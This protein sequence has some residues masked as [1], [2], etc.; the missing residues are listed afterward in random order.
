MLLTAVLGWAQ[1]SYN[2][3]IFSEDGEPFYVYANGIRQND[4]PETNVKITNLTS[5]AL[6]MRVQFDNKALPTL[7]QNFMPEFGYEHT[8]NI[9]KNLK[10]T[11]KLQYFGRVPLAEAPRTNAATV[12]YHTAENPVEPQQPAVT[13]G[14]NDGTINNNFP[15]DDQTN[16]VQEGQ[17]VSNTTVTTGQPGSVNINM[18]PGGIS[19]NVNTDGG[20]INNSITTTTTISGGTVTTETVT[21]KSHTSTK[22]G[23]TSPR[24]NSVTSHPVTEV[25]NNN[26]TTGSSVIPRPMNPNA[27]VTASVPVAN[28]GCGVPM[29]SEDYEKLK[30]TVDDTPFADNKISVAKAATKSNCLSVEQVKG[31]CELMP[32]DDHKLIYAKYAYDYCTDKK[33]YYQVG[34]SFSF[35]STQQKLNKFLQTK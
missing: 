5:E 35:P 34:D 23:T 24:H 32:M 18:T 21:T 11:M 33:N 10:K 6:S 25:T 9:K 28:A 19:M 2:I 26:A 15:T 30:N 22:S 16:V 13:S 20:T 27:T 1:G 17:Q 7:K 12:Q 14:V 4:K 8:V 29:N 31:L 3:V